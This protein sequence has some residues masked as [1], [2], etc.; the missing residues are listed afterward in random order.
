M[1]WARRTREPTRT[2]VAREIWA[3]QRGIYGVLGWWRGLG[4]WEERE[5]KRAYEIDSQGLERSD[6]RRLGPVG[7]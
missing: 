7:T 5:G 1:H 3:R 2:E 4:W 6:I